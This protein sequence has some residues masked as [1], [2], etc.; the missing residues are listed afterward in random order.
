MGNDGIIPI[1]QWTYDG[2]HVLLVK[3][4]DPDGTSYGGFVW[5]ESGP[6]NPG[7]WS[8]EPTCGSGGLFGWPWGFHLN[9]GKVR[10]ATDRWI[11]FR[12]RPED[13]IWIG[14]KAKAV[15]SEDGVLPEV[16]YCGTLAGAMKFTMG[17]RVAWVEAN[18]EGEASA[19]GDGGSASSTGLEGS[20]SATGDRGSAS[21]TGTGVRPPPRGS[22]GWPSPI[23]GR[24][25]E[26]RES[27]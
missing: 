4:V 10:K 20:A 8:R 27:S 12:A 14:E 6:V 16:V 26:K 1:H 17:G 13:V 22:G 3:A 24:W 18:S 5:P 19:T 2:E 21:A 7:T 9:E 15:P 25:P 11:V 23:I